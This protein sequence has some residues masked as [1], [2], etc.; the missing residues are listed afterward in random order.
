MEL[1]WQRRKATQPG[2]QLLE[3]RI[4]SDLCL[5]IRTELSYYVH[6]SR[7]RSNVLAAEPPGE[8]SLRYRDIIGSRQFNLSL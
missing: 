3:G 7:I 6:F 1:S 5:S 4:Q 2:L 8:R